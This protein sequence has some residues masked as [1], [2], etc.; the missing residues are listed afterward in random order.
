M[1]L[2]KKNKKT[3]TKNP[4]SA[5]PRMESHPELK[6]ADAAPASRP[7]APQMGMPHQ[8][9]PQ[10]IL[11]PNV[12]SKIAVAS[13]KGG[14]GKSTVA[15]NLAI[16]LAQDGAQVGLMDADAYGPSIPTMMGAKEQPQTSP[17][18]KLIPIV[19]HGIKLMSIGFLVPDEQA[20]I[21]RGPMLHS[22]VRQFLGD[23]IWG[24]LDYLIIDLPPGTGDVALSLTQSI[25]LTGGVIVTTPQD[26]ALADVRRG[27]AMFDK[28]GVPI[29]G[30]VENMSYFACPHCGERTDI[31]RRHGGVK[32]SEKL[33]TRFLGEIPLDAEVCTAGDLGVPIVA[34]HPDSPQSQAFRSVAHQLV[35]VLSDQDSDDELKII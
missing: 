9:Q 14:V 31:F 8:G 15:T 4:E 23:V 33:G 17:E 27:A 10:N 28:L 5:K 22:A 19:R 12:K 3:E 7:A 11:I 32:T 1:N 25:P 13:G 21:W 26:V 30:V 6:M 20:L 18:K 29:L 34:S 35:E 2:F 16:A 24:E